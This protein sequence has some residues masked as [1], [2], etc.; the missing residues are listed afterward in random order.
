MPWASRAA[1][2]LVIGDGLGP[3]DG[4]AGEL[5]VVDGVAVADADGDGV[6]EARSRDLADWPV[7]PDLI[8][9]LLADGL[10]DAEGLEV[11]L[12][13]ADGLGVPD[14]EGLGDGEAPGDG[15]GTRA[16]SRLG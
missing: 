2:S 8:A 4:L 3:G 5:G 9:A 7:P 14:G 1:G 15:T 12:G 13:L 6:G 11:P 16:S 10:A